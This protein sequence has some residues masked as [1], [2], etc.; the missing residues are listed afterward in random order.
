MSEDI[1]ELTIN[2]DALRIRDYA[3]LMRVANNTATPDEV[4]ELLER[5]YPGAA[6]LPLRALP[7]LARKIADEVAQV[8][9]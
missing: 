3:T 9:A 6:D 2:I 4:I 5:V 7:I 8:K 1:T